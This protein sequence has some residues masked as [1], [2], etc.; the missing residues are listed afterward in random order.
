MSLQRLLQCVPDALEELPLC[1]SSTLL[2]PFLLVSRCHLAPH[3]H[4]ELGLQAS[5]D[6]S[7]MKSCILSND[8]NTMGRRF[9]AIS[10]GPSS[11][12]VLQV[13]NRLNVLDRHPD[14]ANEGV[15]DAV[16]R[17]IIT[18]IRYPGA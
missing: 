9:D 4:G 13:L 7:F 8:D 2:L 5:S 17:Q 6:A 15:S 12:R 18:F 11:L 16:K 3:G 1:R 14:P 10:H